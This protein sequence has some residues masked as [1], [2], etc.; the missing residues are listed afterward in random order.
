MTRYVLDASVIVKWLFPERPDEVDTDKALGLLAG[1]RSGTVAIIQPPHWLAEV[2]AVC[3]RLQPQAANR[4][5]TNLLAMA[6]P[7]VDSPPIYLAACR[8]AERFQHHLFDTLYHAVALHE[9]DAVLVTADG[10][11]YDKAQSAGA[12]IRLADA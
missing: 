11:Y 9:P 7:V 12:I 6:L 1:I 4:I 10:R 3:T 2:A 5:V 8:L